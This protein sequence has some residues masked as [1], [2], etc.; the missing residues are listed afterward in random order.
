MIVS[1]AHKFVLLAP[2]KTASSTCHLRLEQYNESRYNRFFGFN[3]EL[4]RVVHQHLTYADFLGLPESKLGYLTGAFVRNPYD[5]VYS[6]FIQIQRDMLDQPKIQLEESW[7]GQLMLQQI[8][9]VAGSLIKSQFDF[10]TWFDRLED[11]V[12]FNTGRDSNLPLFPSNYWTGLHGQI[13]VDFI[14]RVESFEED[15]R[16]F[17]TLVGIEETSSENENVSAEA[18]L[19][20][21]SEQPKYLGKMTCNTLRKINR[22]FEVDF[23]LFDYQMFRDTL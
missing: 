9:E 5:R 3:A 15:F 4:Q 21:P 6:G 11:H 7:V 23:S 1:N 12:F 10:N 17:C 8:A 22:I 14:G 13:N 19:G 16:R 2:W 18:V 20:S